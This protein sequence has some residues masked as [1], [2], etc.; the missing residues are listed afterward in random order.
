MDARFAAQDDKIDKLDLR[1][2]AQ[3]NKLDDKIG[4]LD[5]KLTALIAALEASGTIDGVVENQ[6]TAPRPEGSEAGAG[7]PTSPGRRAGT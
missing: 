2:T 3:I 5:L 1:L 7:G 4:E 6:T